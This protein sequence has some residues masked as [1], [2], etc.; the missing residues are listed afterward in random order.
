MKK[1]I[2]F[3]FVYEDKYQNCF[4]KY[5]SIQNHMFRIINDS[6]LYEYL[7]LMIYVWMNERNK[8]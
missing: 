3:E 7:K 8:L 6:L 1:L 5:T 2:T 4:L